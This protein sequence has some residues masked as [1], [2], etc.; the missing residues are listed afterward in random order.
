MFGPNWNQPAIFRLAPYPRTALPASRRTSVMLAVARN[1]DAKKSSEEEVE[2]KVKEYD[3]NYK[4]WI[5]KTLCAGAYGSMEAEANGFVHHVQQDLTQLTRLAQLDA[6]DGMDP[7]LFPALGGGADADAGLGGTSI[8]TVTRRSRRPLQRLQRLQLRL[9]LVLF[10]YYLI[11]PYSSPSQSIHWSKPRRKPKPTA[12]FQPSKPG[13]SNFG[14][15]RWKERGARR[16]GRRVMNI[17]HGDEYQEDESEEDQ[18]NKD[19]QEKDK[20]MRKEEV[21]YERNEERS[22]EGV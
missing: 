1:V 2:K 7:G 10:Q 14:G 5:E 11:S 18:E 9:R 3:D 21:E 8:G 13:L 16:R 22:G 17:E 19:R 6:E 20:E 15:A 4:R 12:Q